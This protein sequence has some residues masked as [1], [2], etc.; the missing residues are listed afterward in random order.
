MPGCRLKCSKLSGRIV[1][2]QHTRPPSHPGGATSTVA[3]TPHQG[4]GLGASE[5]HL[6]VWALGNSAMVGMLG[7]CRLGAGGSGACDCQQS[8]SMSTQRATNADAQTQAARARPVG[9]RARGRHGPRLQL[10]GPRAWRTPALWAQLQ[11]R[12]EKPHATAYSRGQGRERANTER[13]PQQPP[14]PCACRAGERRGEARR[15][16]AAAARHPSRPAAGAW[17]GRSRRK[18]QRPAKQR[19]A[20]VGA[21]LPHSHGAR[22]VLGREDRRMGELGWP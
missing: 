10:C 4:E 11:R 9:V 21:A 22:G 15:G 12:P 18:E 20:R 16:A 19:P 14:Q 2:D 17:K 3:F 8:P 6:G 5:R 13:L 1:R 7:E